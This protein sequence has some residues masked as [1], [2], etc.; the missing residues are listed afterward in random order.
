MRVRVRVG[1][2]AR[3]RAR[4]RVRVGVR[5]LQRDELLRPGEGV[6]DEELELDAVGH[7]RLD[8]VRVRVKGER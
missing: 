2:R 7:L 4:A 3:F 1:V 8:L 5:H 6:E